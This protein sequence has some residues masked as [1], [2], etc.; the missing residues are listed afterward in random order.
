MHRGFCCYG[1][2][3]LVSIILFGTFSDTTESLLLLQLL[4]PQILF[5]SQLS[6]VTVLHKKLQ[7]TTL[8]PRRPLIELL[9]MF[10]HSKTPSIGISQI[11]VNVFEIPRDL[12]QVKASH[13]PSFI[14]NSNTGQP[15]VLINVR[16][17]FT[18]IAA[19]NHPQNIFCAM[20]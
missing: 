9:I 2:P 11:C 17:L 19:I 20:E 18:L 3:S 12:I 1:N 16:S 8:I 15:S 4:L 7:N 13:N 6:A 5:F 10:T 14:F